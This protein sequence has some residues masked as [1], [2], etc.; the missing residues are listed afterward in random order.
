MFL[1]IRSIF[2]CVVLKRK[3]L[4]I[5]IKKFMGKNTI[6]TSEKHETEAAFHGCS[7]KRQLSNI[8]PNSQ[9][10]TYARTS[11]QVLLLNLAIF[12]VKLLWKT[13]AGDCFWWKAFWAISTLKMYELNSGHH[14]F[15]V[16][17]F[18]Y[19]YPFSLLDFT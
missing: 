9:E 18:Q 3:K 17:H 6:E 15:F 19:S 13:P 8:L 10:N 11:T 4:E 1:H 16:I 2:F 14:S 5:T 7:V 12:S